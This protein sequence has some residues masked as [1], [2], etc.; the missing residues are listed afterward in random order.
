[1]PSSFSLSMASCVGH[2][3]GVEEKLRPSF[4]LDFVDGRACIGVVMSVA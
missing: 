2:W 3:A 4:L 1:M